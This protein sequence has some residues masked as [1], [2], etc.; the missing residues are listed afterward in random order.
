[1]GTTN[2]DIVQANT[3]KDANENVI[4]S[5]LP[6]GVTDGQSTTDGSSN[7][8]LTYGVVSSAVNN[9]KV[10]NAATTDNPIIEA[11][12]SDTNIGIAIKP[13]GAGGIVLGDGA[14]VPFITADTT[15]FGLNA[16]SG[17]AGIL[18]STTGTLSLSG[19]IVRSLIGTSSGAGAIDITAG[20]HEITTTGTG[21]ALTLADGTAGQEIIILYVAETA[22][23][24]TAV[25]TPT[26]FANGSTL[27]FNNVGDSAHLV[28]S[29]TGGWYMIGGEAVVA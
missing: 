20:I 4:G 8:L 7:E 29:S 14:N 26:T 18:L 11:V 13:K 23:A 12:G 9:L 5:G 24:D 16:A 6:S 1:M 22:G 19:A 15:D 25:L 17:L 2:F 21:D 28:Y 10:S 3:F 27:T